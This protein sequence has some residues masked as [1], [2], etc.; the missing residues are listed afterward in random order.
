MYLFS[1]LCTR[2]YSV[3]GDYVVGAFKMEI[4]KSP[5]RSGGNSPGNVPEI[6]QSSDTEGN[7]LSCMALYRN[8]KGYKMANQVLTMMHKN[9]L[10]SLFY[11]EENRFLYK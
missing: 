4:G 8:C 2:T 3:S 10:Q 7:M 5:R 1:D 9:C 6:L 11:M